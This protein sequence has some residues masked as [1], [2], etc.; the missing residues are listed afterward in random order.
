M[1]PSIL[2]LCRDFRF[3]DN[4]ALAAA[5]AAGPVLP[6]FLIDAALRAQGAASRWRLQRTLLAFDAELRRRHGTGVLV[7]QGEPWDILPTLGARIGAGSL[8]MNDWPDP[9][10]IAAQQR[11]GRALA[12][13]ALR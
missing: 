5:A 3:R 11:L 4:A 7:L 6:V 10:T 8:H 9:A 2:W 1:P 12:G 13:T